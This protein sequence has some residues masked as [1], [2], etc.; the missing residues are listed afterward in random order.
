MLAKTQ[1]KKKNQIKFHIF[2]FRPTF[3]MSYLNVYPHQKCKKHLCY[4]LFW[5]KVKYRWFGWT[6]TISFCSIQISPRKK[7]FFR[8]SLRN[9]ACEKKNFSRRKIKITYFAFSPRNVAEKLRNISRRDP[10][11]FRGESPRNFAMGR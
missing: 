6:I 8:V 3:D 4:N 9:T 10:G 11:R 2:R 1:K 7:L 5:V